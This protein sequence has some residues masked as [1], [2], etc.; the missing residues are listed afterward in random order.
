MVF[1][2][3]VSLKNL[4]FSLLLYNVYI[5]ILAKCSKSATGGTAGD[6]DGSAKGNCATDGEICFG[7]GSCGGLYSLTINILTW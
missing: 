6:G 5:M 4:T 7:D 3:V 2:L 1:S